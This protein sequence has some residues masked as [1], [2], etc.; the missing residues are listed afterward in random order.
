[1][2]GVGG[3]AGCCLL[4]VMLVKGEGRVECCVRMLCALGGAS[5]GCMVAQTE[6]SPAENRRFYFLGIVRL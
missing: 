5:E 6:S 2:A 3:G 1:M 4:A